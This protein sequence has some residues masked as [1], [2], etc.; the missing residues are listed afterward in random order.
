LR[1]TGFFSAAKT[2]VN[3]SFNQEELNSLEVMLPPHSE[4]AA[5]ATYLKNET[6]KID[7]IISKTQTSLE[8]LQEYRRSLITAAVTGKLEISE[9]EADV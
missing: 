4:Q 6:S 9:V 1:N 2:R 5:I 7:D 8:K 3:N